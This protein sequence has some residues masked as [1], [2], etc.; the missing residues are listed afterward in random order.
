MRTNCVKLSET[1]VRRECVSR[2]F[3]WHAV[4]M[5]SSGICSSLETTSLPQT[6]LR[7]LAHVTHLAARAPNERFYG[8]AQLKMCFRGAINVKANN[9]SQLLRIH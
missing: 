6:R 3:A 1:Q 4:R 2:A 9:S 7:R 5:T 8:G